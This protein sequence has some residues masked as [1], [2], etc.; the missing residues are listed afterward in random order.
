MLTEL[1]IGM[2]TNYRTALR[3]ECAII[4]IGSL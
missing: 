2:S 3:E 1:K 4:D